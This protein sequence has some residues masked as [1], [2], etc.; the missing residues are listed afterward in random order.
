MLL[1]NLWA[2][3]TCQSIQHQHRHEEFSPGSPQ[4]SKNI[5]V[6]LQSLY[7]VF[8]SNKQGFGH[9]NFSESTYATPIIA[10][11]YTAASIIRHLFILLCRPE[12]VVL[13]TKRQ[14]EWIFGQRP[15]LLL[16]LLLL[17]DCFCLNANVMGP[18]YAIDALNSLRDSIHK[19]III[20]IL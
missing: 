20:S 16:V 2:N 10:N 12:Y 14:W 6:V 11:K 19:L 4:S 18:T 8:Q 3:R 15:L 13:I 1:T 17:C 9:T 5:V 7:A